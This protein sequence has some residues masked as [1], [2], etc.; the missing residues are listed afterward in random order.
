MDHEAGD[1]LRVKILD[2]RPQRFLIEIPVPEPE[3]D[4]RELV[5]RMQKFLSQLSDHN[6]LSPLKTG[7]PLNL[8]AKISYRRTRLF[9]LEIPY[10]FIIP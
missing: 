6:F 8:P 3:R 7:P 5:G 4:R 9:P 10:F 1:A 2:L